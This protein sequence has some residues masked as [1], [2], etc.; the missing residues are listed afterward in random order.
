MPVIPPAVAAV[1]V[2]VQQLTP[3]RPRPSPVRTAVAGFMATAAVA[4]M[5]ASAAGFRRAGTTLDPNAAIRT[6]HIVETGAYAYS[7]NPM[8][9]GLVT[10]TAAN[11]V[12]LGG[13]LAWLPVVATWVWLDRGQIVREEL[14]L[15]RAFG[16]E[17]VEYTERVR[18]WI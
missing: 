9:A 10:L 2:T 1:A 3:G 16:R 18:R 13:V 5:T 4:V 6:T 17:Y 11:A 14:V 12:R 8:Y 15:E 7:R